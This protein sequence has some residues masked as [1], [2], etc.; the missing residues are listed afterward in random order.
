MKNKDIMNIIDRAKIN[1]WGLNAQFDDLSVSGSNK[2]ITRTF[3]TMVHWDIQH[4]TNIL[5]KSIKDKLSHVIPLRLLFLP[6][7]FA[8]P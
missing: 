2:F 7:S 6:E 5:S 4:G 1:A 8:L 3:S